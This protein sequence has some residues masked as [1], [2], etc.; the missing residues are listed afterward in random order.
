MSLSSGK[1]SPDFSPSLDA[2]PD[3]RLPLELDPSRRSVPRETSLSRRSRGQNYPL[4]ASLKK[5]GTEIVNCVTLWSPTETTS[6]QTYKIPVAVVANNDKTVSI[7]NVK[8]SE[9]LEQLTLP[10]YVNRA[11]MSPDG[12]LL[13]TICDDPFLYIYQRKQKPDARRERSESRYRISYEW[14][15]WGRIQLSGQRQSDK[16]NMRGSF[17]ASFSKSGKYLAVA[18]QYGIISVF[19]TETLTQDDADPLM[20]V[21][22]TSRPNRECGAVRAMDFSPGPFDL[23]AWTESTGRVGVADVRSL[24]F[25]RQLIAIDSEAEGVEQV[26]VSERTGDPVIDQRLRSF[27]TDS[28]SSSSTTPDYLGMDFERRQLRYLTREPLDRHQSPLTAQETEV[29]QA[30]RIARRQRDAANAAREALTEAAGTPSRWGA[31]ADGQRSSSSN[32]EGS[33]STDRRISTTGLPAAIREFVNP[34][35]AA[36]SFRSFINDR[37]QDR[38]RRA[39]HL[40]PRRRSSMILAATEQALEQENLDLT[41]T[42]NGNETSSGLERLTLTPPRLPA[43]GSDSPN[44]PWAEIDPLYSSRFTTDPPLDRSTRLRIEAEDDDRRDFAHR[45]R[46][47]WRPEEL[48]QTGLSARQMDNI[49]GQVLRAAAGTIETMGCCWSEDGRML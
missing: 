1:S 35:R 15:L 2:D 39:Q 45:L 6:D 44:N 46:Q 5:V 3:A 37:N 48:A 9:I 4:S 43:I 49:V 17:A 18:T 27:R 28:P 33:G 41:M 36:A 25:S 42:R 16:C 47:P 12:E 8:E 23:L 24:F 11:V 22:T 40:E 32:A 29:L 13:V 10:D 26:I 38:E 31:W 19:D 20:V 34:D 14:V 7:L 21:F 30:H